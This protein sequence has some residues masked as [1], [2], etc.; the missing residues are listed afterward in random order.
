M[1]MSS[2]EARRLRETVRREVTDR[3]FSKSFAAKI[4]EQYPGCPPGVNA[5][6][7]S[8]RHRAASR[9]IPLDPSVSEAERTARGRTVPKLGRLRISSI[10]RPLWVATMPAPRAGRIRSMQPHPWQLLVVTLAGW[11]NRFQQDAIEYLKEENRVLREQLGGRRL[12]FTDEQRRRLAAKARALGRDGLKEVAG[13]VTPDTL[14]RW[15]TRLIAKKYDGSKRRGPGRPRVAETIRELVVRMATQNSTWGYTRI[16]GAL[17][18]L[19]H[20]VGRNTVKR[21]LAEHGIESAPERR[22]RIP[23]GTFLKAHWGAIAAT[24]FFTVEVLTSSGLIRYFVLFV[25]DLKTRRVEI[26]GITNQ[27]YDDWMTQ[28]ARNLTDAIDGFL[29]DTR[30]LIHDR[31]PLFSASF[32]ATLRGVDV[33]T[34]KLPARS[35]DLNAYAERFVRSIKSECLSRMIPL[36]ENHLRA[37]IRAFVAHYHLERNHQGLDNELITPSRESCRSDGRIECRERL[38]GTLRYYYREAA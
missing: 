38:G 30:F 19:G 3:G 17:R 32:R 14:L 26:A 4:R 11:V 27:P 2:C 16:C 29:R 18:N 10:S 15:Y 7:Y 31:D 13:L 33:E 22:K 36:G 9:R 28:I 34:V 20:D 21:I 1:P 6:I 25:I 12:R 8:S 37:S 5:E 23:W 24:D 35:S